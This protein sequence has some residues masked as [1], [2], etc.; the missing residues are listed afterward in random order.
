MPPSG[1]GKINSPRADA[2]HLRP[3]V[4][5]LLYTGARAGEAVWLDWRNVD[6]TRVHVIIPKTKNG[7]AR[8]VPL[9]QR[10]VT[11]L[12]NL[13]HREDEVFRRPDGLP[14]ERPDEDDDDTSAGSRIAKA[15][16]GACQR[17][18][19]TDFHPHDCRHT[20]ATWHYWANRD[21]GALERLGGLKTDRMVL[22]Y[23]H[24]NVDEQKVTK[25]KPHSLQHVKAW[26]PISLVRCIGAPEKL[27]AMSR[28]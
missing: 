13:P 8:G 28:T 27:A 14:Y 22:R 7:E 21:L 4:I 2:R 25:Q 6:L 20:W 15:F 11:A 26:H 3:L 23:A 16:K 10:V 17:A 18:R 5:F 1:F 9:H 12:A 24:T 19:I